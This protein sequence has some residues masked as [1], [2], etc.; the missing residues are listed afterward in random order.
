MLIFC[1]VLKIV[2]LPSA[3]NL[4]VVGIESLVSA[5]ADVVVA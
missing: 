5:S 2:H 4:G 1:C 3:I